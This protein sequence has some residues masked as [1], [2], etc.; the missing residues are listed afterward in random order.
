MQ[1][2]KELNKKEKKASIGESKEAGN[3]L[4]I[5]SKSTAYPSE[6]LDTLGITTPIRKPLHYL[7]LLKFQLLSWGIPMVTINEFLLMENSTK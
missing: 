7:A 6:I 5:I 1:L 4:G 3:T 2:P